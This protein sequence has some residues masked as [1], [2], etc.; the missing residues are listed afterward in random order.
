[1][2]QLMTNVLVLGRSGS[3]KSAFIN[4]IYGTY[5]R[6]TGTG[7]PVTRKGLHKVVQV[8]Q[9]ITVNLYDT[10]GLEANKSEE[11]KQVILSEVQKHNESFQIR[12]WFHTIFYCLSIQRARVE[13][14]E[15]E[16]IINPLLEQG[17]RI[18]VIL[19]H[20]DVPEAKMKSQEMIKRLLETTQLT[21]QVIILVA[22]E[23]KQLLGGS[24]KGKFGKEKVL[25]SMKQNLWSDI[26]EKLPN[27]YSAYLERQ[28]T[29]WKDNSYIRVEEKINFIN[30]RLIAKKIIGE[31]NEELTQLLKS[32][33]GETENYLYTSYTY[34]N[35]L[36]YY[37]ATGRAT[38][39]AQADLA[40]KKHYVYFEA[41]R[42]SYLTTSLFGAMPLVNIVLFYTIHQQRKKKMKR[43]INRTYN[44][45]MEA[46]PIYVEIFRQIIDSYGKEIS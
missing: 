35:Q 36:V 15:I 9:Q 45:L 23:A 33:D 25:L 18:V 26:Q 3:G 14:F 31:V 6:K 42:L 16:E 2:N 40:H 29:L 1:M 21:E 20:G 37:L 7:K 46:V 4:Y 28:F 34:Y 41:D 27:N 13:D 11:W 24:S 44:Q 5:K 8:Y 10:W 43:A 22:S 32:I 17:N 19:T 12:D 38:L 30:Q 39:D